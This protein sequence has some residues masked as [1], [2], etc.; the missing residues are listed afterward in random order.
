VLDAVPLVD[1]A[2]PRTAHGAIGPELP[3]PCDAGQQV[4]MVTEI[5]GKGGTTSV[6]AAPGFDDGV[7]REPLLRCD[8]RLPCALDRFS[9]GV[10]DNLA[11]EPAPAAQQRVVEGD[12][13][14][15][16]GPLVAQRSA[17][18]HLLPLAHDRMPRPPCNPIINSF[19]QKSCLDRFHAQ[20]IIF[21][22]AERPRPARWFTVFGS[23][24]MPA[25]DAAAR[26]P[27]L[28]L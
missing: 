22:P 2:K 26:L 27:R 15:L 16:S 23:G 6:F 11:V 17:D 19:G 10:S 5:L 4:L 3:A 21:A 18:A 25:A 28:D 9:V 8:D 24:A 20:T 12:L 14:G 13:Q 7:H 1:D